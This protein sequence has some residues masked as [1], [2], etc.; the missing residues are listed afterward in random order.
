MSDDRATAQPGKQVFAVRPAAAPTLADTS[1]GPGA[2]RMAGWSGLAGQAWL[3]RLGY[4]GSGH[5]E[6]AG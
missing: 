3:V 2:A 6:Q 4:E 5:V 1:A